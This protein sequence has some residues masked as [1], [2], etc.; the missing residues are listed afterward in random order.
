MRK[1]KLAIINSL[2]HNV[3]TSIFAFPEVWE[4][5]HVVISVNALII[6]GISCKKL[7]L[8]VFSTHLVSH[9]PVS[10]WPIYFF[11]T[12]VRFADTEKK[13]ITSLIILTKF[14]ML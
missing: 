4:S 11:K 8:H 14:R 13:L 3:I 12:M 5:F 10:W 7:V 2:S 6:L 1:T 9:N